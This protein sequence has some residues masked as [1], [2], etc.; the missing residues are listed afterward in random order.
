METSILRTLA[1]P[2]VILPFIGERLRLRFYNATSRA[3][4]S[5]NSW[6]LRPSTGRVRSS[7]KAPA[8]VIDSLLVAVPS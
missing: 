6:V 2:G 7:Q 3:A 8:L 5:K 1:F 4:I